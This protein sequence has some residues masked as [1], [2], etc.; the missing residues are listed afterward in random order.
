VIP[1]RHSVLAIDDDPDICNLLK[2]YLKFEDIDVRT[3][4]NR[5]EV[6]EQFRS[7]ALPDLVLLDVVMPTINGFDLLGSMRNQT[8]LKGLPVIMLTA[9][10][11]RGGVLRGITGGADGY[12]TKPFQIQPLVCAIKAVLGLEYSPQEVVWDSL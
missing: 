2:L 6:I 9:E 8:A 7:N 3:A 1:K 5:A 10:S 12:V 4:C 11:S